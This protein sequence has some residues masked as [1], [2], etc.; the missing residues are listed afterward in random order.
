MLRSFRALTF[1]MLA[2]LTQASEAFSVV[3]F[4]DDWA[5]I[6]RL[7]AR[8][9]IARKSAKLR[10]ACWTESRTLNSHAAFRIDP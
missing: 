6:Y 5:S 10:L 9:E 1:F 2:P 4:F 7:S 8:L 3:Y